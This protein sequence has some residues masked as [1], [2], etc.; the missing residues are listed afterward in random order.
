ML[1]GIVARYT[2][3][4]LLLGIA[5]LVGCASDP[6]RGAGS[7]GEGG[8]DDDA[9]GSGSDSS[10]SEG[11]SGT[12]GAGTSGTT[13]S[14]TSTGVGAGGAGT[15]STGAGGATGLEGFCEHYFECGG[16]YYADVQACVDEAVAY[17]GECRRP[18]LD[19]FGDCMIGVSCEEWGNPEAYDPAS[20]PCARQWQA[21]T[22]KDC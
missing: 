17:W 12:G 3:I 10:G 5:W 7:A 15:T 16:S 9:S 11:S 21:V 19:A 1:A 2:G 14:G 22:A 6:G 13:S 18:E 8:S 4:T 20:T